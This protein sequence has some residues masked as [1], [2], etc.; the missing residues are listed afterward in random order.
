MSL[1]DI[2]RLVALL[3]AFYFLAPYLLSGINRLFIN[4]IV[5]V[6]YPTAVDGHVTASSMNRQYFLYTLD[7][8]TKTSYDSNVFVP[9][10]AS[11]H[12]GNLS[13]EEV[14]RL[15]LGTQ[16]RVGDYITKAANSTSLTVQRGTVT[17]H[18]ICPPAEATK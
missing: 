4:P 14:N 10:T 9:A 18:W 5:E 8:D 12:T 13:Q 1:K 15:I 17:T 3:A 6:S 16:L 2:L 11:S 7:G